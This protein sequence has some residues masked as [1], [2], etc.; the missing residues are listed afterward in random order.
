MAEREWMRV[1]ESD[2]REQAHE[3]A[4]EQPEDAFMSE[5][6]RLPFFSRLCLFFPTIAFL[7]F[8]ASGCSFPRIVLY[9]SNLWSCNALRG[10]LERALR[11]SQED[12]RRLRQQVT[13]HLTLVM[14]PI[15][16]YFL[17]GEGVA[18]E[19]RRLTATEA[20]GYSSI[21]TSS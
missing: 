2:E 9:F 18:D 14:F 19:P 21:I 4:H 6:D 11:T 12:S 17:A 1:K 15:A 20:T 8:H 3:Q 10:R 7:L 13:Y 16:Y 5:H